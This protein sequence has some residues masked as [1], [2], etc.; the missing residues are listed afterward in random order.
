[1]LVHA[2]INPTVTSNQETLLSVKNASGHTCIEHTGDEQVLQLWSYTIKKNHIIFS[3]TIILTLII[4]RSINQLLLHRTDS[5]RC[6]RNV[7]IDVWIANKVRFI[8]YF[9][10]FSLSENIKEYYKQAIF[11]YVK[12]VILAGRH[13]IP[14]ATLDTHDSLRS[15]P[16]P[17]YSIFPHSL[18]SINSHWVS[19]LDN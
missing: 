17:L 14:S 12:R 9:Y 10:L 13:K 5:V 2:R 16:L 3:L 19:F 4:L 7:L 8:I 6:F 11:K 1:M 18:A 15:C